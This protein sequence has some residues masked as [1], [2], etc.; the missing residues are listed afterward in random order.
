MQNSAIE[1]VVA[2]SGSSIMIWDARGTMCIALDADQAGR[3]IVDLCDDES[4]P[5]VEFK[6]D[7]TFTRIG[8]A[9]LDKLKAPKSQ[10]DDEAV[11]V[12]LV[13]MLVPQSDERFCATLWPGKGGPKTFTSP[14]ELGRALFELAGDPTQPRVPA[15]APLDPSGALLERGAQWLANDLFGQGG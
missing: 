12:Q 10:A 13:A 5:R 2:P 11:A 7:V 4:V 9:F 14:S 15:G 3:F 6:R 1:I 8:H